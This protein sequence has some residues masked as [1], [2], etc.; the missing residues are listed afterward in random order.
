MVRLCALL[1]LVALSPLLLLIAIAIVLD[2]GL[3]VLFRQTR[4]GIEGR[5][6]RV[7]KFRSMRSGNLGLQVTSGNDSRVTRVGRFIR[8]YKLDELPQLWNLFRGHMNI[9][10]PRPE[11]PIFVNAADPLWR[12]TLLVKPGITCLATLVYRNEEDLL[13]RMPN[14]EQYYREILAPEKLRLNLNYLKHRCLL[15]DWKLLQ[16]T[17]LSSLLPARYDSEQVKRILIDKECMQ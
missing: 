3:P 2:D 11:V 4:V 7:V 15:S 9:V 8:R 14:P 5:L 12:S 17:V 13:A 10:G 6:F 16:L 1:A